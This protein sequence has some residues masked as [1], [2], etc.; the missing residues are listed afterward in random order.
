MLHQSARLYIRNSAGTLEEPWV[1]CETTNGDLVIPRV[2]LGDDGEYFV[3]P[4]Q[5]ATLGLCSVF[6]VSFN[7]RTITLL[8]VCYA[9][10]FSDV[11]FARRQ[12]LKS[13]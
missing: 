2:W 3:V 13:F 4:S 12:V 7:I 8:A 10:L 11:G 1:E 6:L 5:T 9:A